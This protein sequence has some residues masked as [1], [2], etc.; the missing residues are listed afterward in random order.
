MALIWI[1]MR[2]PSA[3][4]AVWG[5]A[6]RKATHW[7]ESPNA[8]SNGTEVADKKSLELE[9]LDPVDVSEVEAIVEEAMVY[10]FEPFVVPGRNAL[11]ELWANLQSGHLLAQGKHCETGERRAIPASDWAHLDWLGDPAASAD[12][13]GIRTEN[14]P[15]YDEVNVPAQMV[16]EIWPSL[17]EFLSEEF[18]REDWTVE[19]ARLWVAY[20]NRALFHFVGLSGPR[21]QVQF[22][23]AEP[24]DS[25]PTR[26][27][28]HAL[29]TGKLRAIRNGREMPPEYWFGKEKLPR[30]QPEPKRIYL[31]RS[32]VMRV[33]KDK[34]LIAASAKSEGIAIKQLPSLLKENPEMTRANA[35]LRL[36]DE[37]FEVRP[38]G[39]QDRVWPEAR[40]QAGLPRF[41]RAGRKTK[42]P[43]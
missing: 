16:R 12:M 30:R 34:P 14:L 20:R 21:A 32:D 40:E 22:D 13:V 10:M 11:T 33:F 27:L 29:K 1:V 8:E 5:K 24:R 38:R 23:K 3:V 36:R 4:R 41:A 17:D 19:A 2:D 39:F 9:P 43:H 7:V 37:G 6:R 25:T 15:H 18:Y 31:R 28:L 26:T 42:S 35:H